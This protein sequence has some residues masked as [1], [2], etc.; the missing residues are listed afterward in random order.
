MAWGRPRYSYEDI[1]VK[2]KVEPRVNNNGEITLKIESDVTTLISGSTPGRP[3]IGKRSIKTI[4]RLRDGETAIFGGLLKD[5]EQK[6]LQGIWG[7]ADI[8]LIGGLLGNHNNNTAKTDVLLTIRAVLVRKTGH[9]RAGHGSLQSGRRHRE[10]RSL[11]T[12]GPK[13]DPWFRSGHDSARS[14]PGSGSKPAC[15]SGPALR[16]PSCDP[17]SPGAADPGPAGCHATHC[18]T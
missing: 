5:E 18:S 3:D 13:E 10:S 6:S 12:S 15:P 14:E 9:D 11:C 8:P 7:L 4:A 2:I 1:G 16:S 17:A